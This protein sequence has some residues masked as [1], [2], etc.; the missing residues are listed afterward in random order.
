MPEP[1]HTAAAGVSLMTLAVAL[2]GP[3]AG[4]Y[5]VILLGSIA[6]SLWALSS[7][8]IATRA[9]GAWMMARCVITAIVLTALAAQLVGPY[10]GMPVDEAYAIVSFLIGALGN[11]WQEIFDTIKTRIQGLI[12][13]SG[14]KP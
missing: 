2:A 14:P 7:V 11:R 6:G 10:I 4:P 13:V 5:V 1:L 9:Q 8:E 12:T 3:H